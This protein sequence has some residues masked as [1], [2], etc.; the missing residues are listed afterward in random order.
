M[1]LRI[2]YARP[3]ELR[4][5]YN[6]HNVQGFIRLR[7]TPQRGVHP[8]HLLTN[9]LLGNTIHSLARR[10]YVARCLDNG[11]ECGDVARTKAEQERAASGERSWKIQ[12]LEE[13]KRQ[14]YIVAITS[15][16]IV[17][18]VPVFARS[19]ARK[20]TVKCVNCK[21]VDNLRSSP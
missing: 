15:D 2:F 5:L 7:D 13:K 11:E 17:V 9:I 18:K 14:R 16:E 3:I 6:P 4:S 12:L 10:N 8:R 19:S 1:W 21:T 20:C